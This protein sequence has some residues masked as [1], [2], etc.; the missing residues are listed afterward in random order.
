MEVNP[1]VSIVTVC[2]NSAKSISRTIKSIL[3]QTYDNI[4]Y[5][6]IDGGSTDDTMNV[7]KSFSPF[8]DAR[9]IKYSYFSSNDNG[10]YEAMN[11]G[12]NLSKGQLIGILNSDDFYNDDSVEI[13]VNHFINHANFGIFYGFIRQ[14]LGE[15]E[16]VIHRYNYD[17]IL[18]DLSA[19]IQ[20]AAQHPT[21]FVRNE[22]YAE[23]GLY[24]TSFR[25]AADYDF[26]LRAN[27]LGIKF[28]A[29]D[30]IITNFQLG[31]ASITTSEGIRN[32]E[33]YRAQLNNNKINQIDYDIKTKNTFTSKAVKKI[34]TATKFL[35]NQ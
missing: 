20:S 30:K 24:D 22:V 18:S 29:I 10:I 21:C 2:K 9:N 15:K 17:L 33:R 13:V 35:L 28:Y 1:L 12:I 3:S 32:E 34:K 26:L 7:I 8:F 5:I 27:R 16:L 23:I 25:I 6:I 14:L 11:K 4:E 31:G 19:G